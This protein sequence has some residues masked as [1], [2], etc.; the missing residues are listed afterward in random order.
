MPRKLINR[1]TGQVVSESVILATGPV[2]LFWGAMG[3]GIPP[4]TVLGLTPC[5]WVHT[6]FVPHPLDIVYCDADGRILRVD[7]AAPPNR[8]LRRAPGA[9]TVWESRAGTLSPFVAA[10][11]GLILDLFSVNL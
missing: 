9:K 6:F 4:G 10:G 8:L 5:D 7:A 1:E 11:G 3:R 2:S